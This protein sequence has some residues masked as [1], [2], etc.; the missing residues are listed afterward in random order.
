MR[1]TYQPTTFREERSVKSE[2]EVKVKYG[3]WGAIGGAVVAMVIGFVWGGWT[4]SSTTQKVSEDAVQATRA[5]ICVAQFKN[6]PNFEAKLKE[7]GGVDSYKR[8]EYIET[9]GWDKMPGQEQATWG[10]ASACVAGIEGLVK[11]EATPAG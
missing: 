2:T 1:A 4:T 11:G 3:A 5:A 10:V 6:D 7:F 9:G 8:S